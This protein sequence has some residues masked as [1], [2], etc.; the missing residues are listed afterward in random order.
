MFSNLGTTNYL[1][2]LHDAFGAT[3][4]K[5]VNG[6][7]TYDRQMNLQSDGNVTFEAGNV[8]I[9]NYPFTRHGGTTVSGPDATLHLVSGTGDVSLKIEADIE[10]D[11]EAHNPMIWLAQDGSLVNFKIGLYDSGN[12]AYL[13]WGNATDKDLVLKNNGTEKFRFT[14][15][16]KLGI[17]TSSPGHLLDVDGNARVGT[18]STAGYLYLSAD[19]AGSYLGW[20]ADGS[21]ITL[22]ADDDLV[23]RADDDMLFKNSSTTNM[24]LTSDARVG[25]GN[26]TP[27]YKLD[28]NGTGRFTGDL[29]GNSRIRVDKGAGEV[30]M[31]STDGVFIQEEFIQTGSSAN[32][33]VYDN[34]NLNLSAFVS[35]GNRVTTSGSGTNSAQ[36]IGGK[37][38]LFN[39]VLHGDGSV[40]DHFQSFD[41]TVYVG[42]DDHNVVH[43]KTIHVLY[44]GASTDMIY[45][46]SNV[47]ENNSHFDVGVEYSLGNSTV[48]GAA[49]NNIHVAR[50]YIQLADP[51]S[52]SPNKYNANQ[53][54]WS[55][56]FVGLKDEAHVG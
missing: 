26:N 35:R 48:V 47:M 50:V 32:T 17:G 27:S 53:L 51:S 8:G 46:Y 14:G 41:A 2:I 13:D 1:E 7:S 44:N 6:S 30:E 37:Y 21:D 28:V 38:Y 33:P 12:H 19:S 31:S 16:G 43:R 39:V 4:F 29:L 3:N 10:N 49:T 9:G 54:D 36:A 24:V 40:Q 56:D 45:Q 34:I 18:T 55:W 42:G 52:F 23:L 5:T 25:I 11:T 20:N 22:R 15:D